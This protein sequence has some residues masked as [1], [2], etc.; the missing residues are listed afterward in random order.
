MKFL[1]LMIINSIYDGKIS[2]LEPY[3]NYEFCVE[4]NC[5]APIGFI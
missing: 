1:T 2:Y 3:T 4:L 5:E